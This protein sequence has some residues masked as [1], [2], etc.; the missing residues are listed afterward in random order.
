MLNSQ[1]K[2]EILRALSQKSLNSQRQ[3]SKSSGFSLG[4]VNYC[5]KALK[6]K[7]LIKIKNFKK[8]ENKNTYI[9]LLTPKG[10][11]EKGKLTYDFMKKKM[12]EYDE[13]KSELEEIKNDN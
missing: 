5:L 13:L 2:L 11:M 10:I 8:N 6:S 3:I 1:D 9:Y 7:G 12:V 4:K